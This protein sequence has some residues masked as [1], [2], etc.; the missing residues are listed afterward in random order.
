MEIKLKLFNQKAVRTVWNADEEEWYFSVVDV[1]NVLS[2]SAG[3][4]PGAYWR[5]LKQRL[6]AEGSEFVTKCHELKMQAA[7]GKYYKTDALNT[8]GVLRLIQSIPS[9]KA[10]PFKIWLAQV[11]SERLDEIADPEKAIQR[12][13]AYYREKGYSDEWINQRLRTIEIRKKLTDEWSARGVETDLEYAILTNDMTK[14]WSGLSIKDYKALKGL[15]K[16]SLRDNMTDLE[17]LFNAVAE[18]TT[19]RLSQ[20]E[21]PEGFEES[22]KVAKKGGEATKQARQSIEEVIGEKIVSP[23]N[24]SEKEKLVTEK[25]PEIYKIHGSINNPNSIILCE[26]DYK[27]FDDSLKLVSAKL[28]NALLDFPLIFLGYSLEDENIKKILSDFVNSFDD[29]ILQKIKKSIILVSY[30]PNESN[31]IEGDKQF[32]TKGR[33][34]DITTI[35]TNNFSA[36][37]RYIQELHPTATSYELRRYKQMLVKIL[38]SAEKG[39]KT[40]YV[41]NLDKTDDKDLAVYIATQSEIEEFRKS[42]IL[43]DKNEILEKALFKKPFAYEDFAKDWYNSKK[44]R[45]S[46]YA[47]TFHIKHFLSKPIEEY[48]SNFQNNYRTI[49]KT[50][51]NLAPDEN[52]V[53]EDLSSLKTAIDEIYK[54]SIQDLSKHTKIAKFCWSTLCSNKIQVSEYETLLQ[55]LYQKHPNILNVSEFKK[56]IAYLGYRLYENP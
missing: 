44:I 9:P 36:I 6:K 46:E 4:D 20:K 15:K 51:Q 25:L 45:A 39:T 19:T 48:G 3:K 14:A 41:K 1:C 31:L 38:S 49:K 27:H 34:I 10:E 30:D 5:K 42:T 50:F 55:K 29:A 12:G 53:K 56:A 32:S 35:R 28:L 13:A 18:A 24:A 52:F 54:S 47:P 43:F 21:K 8:K 7:D 26:N 11:G 37:Y 40:I 17:L 22:R 16:E 23:L 2:D 33:S